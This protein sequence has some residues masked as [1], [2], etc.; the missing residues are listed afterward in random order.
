MSITLPVFTGL[1][2]DARIDVVVAQGQIRNEVTEPP[3]VH[4]ITEA[5][6]SV[7]SRVCVA[8]ASALAE[9]AGSLRT[10]NVVM[11]GSLFGAD[12]LPY[13]PTEFTKTVPLS[14]E[15]ERAFKSGVAWSSALS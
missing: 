8:D 10:L 5:I 6:T 4:E 2:R 7:T 3:S 9:Q 13:K 14:E 1:R 11:L 15:N 12:V